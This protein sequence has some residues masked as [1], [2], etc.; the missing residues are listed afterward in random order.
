MLDTSVES[1]SAW[2]VACWL[3]FQ[4]KKRK[5]K[6]NTCYKMSWKHRIEYIQLLYIPDENICVLKE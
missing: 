4:K 1:N 3:T 5:K 6:E 2:A